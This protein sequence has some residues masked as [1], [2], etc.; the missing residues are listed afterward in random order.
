MRLFGYVITNADTL[1]KD[2]QQRFQSFYCGLCRT[3]KNRYGLVGSAT[4]SY[5]MTFL[6][7]LLN[8]LYEPEETVEEARCPVHPIK[9]RQFVDTE[10]LAYVADINVA[11]AYHKCQD[12]WL[13]DHSIPAALEAN[14]LKRAYH[15]VAVN[16][17]QKCKAIED[18][19]KEIHE[20]EIQGIEQ[21]DLPVNATGKMLGELFVYNA[22]DIWADSLR[23]MGDGLGRFI[24]FMDAYDDL[25]GDIRRRRFNP[26]KAYRARDD[27]EEMCRS[28]LMMM[29]ADATGEFEQLP[30]LQDADIIR[31]VLYSGIWSK[32]AY[33]QKKREAKSKGAK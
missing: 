22:E 5:D 6:A 15:K 33:I 3:L 24:Y 18:W 1:P 27:Y 25:P 14:I 4:L 29:I 19:L 8:A 7:L 11:L 21:I 28:A 32:Y 23:I 20:I 2:R 9:R 16:H 12:N 31:N 17:P 13:D 10:V 26:L 30:I